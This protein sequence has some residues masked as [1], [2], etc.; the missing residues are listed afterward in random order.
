MKDVLIILPPIELEPI[1]RT[2]LYL[3]L[4]TG[5]RCIARSPEAAL[6]EREEVLVYQA[7]L[8]KEQT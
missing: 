7:Q 4:G 3:E 1:L 6:A 2:R 5:M 8:P